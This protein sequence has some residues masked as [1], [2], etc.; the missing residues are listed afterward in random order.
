MRFG[1]L[2][3]GPLRASNVLPGRGRVPRCV[4]CPR[5]TGGHDYHA[6]CMVHVTIC[7]HARQQLFGVVTPAGMHLNDPGRF[8]EQ[9]LLGLHADDMGIAID[10]HVVM[11]DHIHAIIVL[12]TNPH[13][14]TTDSIPDVVRRFKMRVMRAWPQGIAQRGWTRYDTHLWHPSYYDTLIRNDIHLE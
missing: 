10:A 5:R 4:S 6:P 3:T 2:S 11:P 7:T 13:A 9:T 8:V 12:G 1:S 14:Q